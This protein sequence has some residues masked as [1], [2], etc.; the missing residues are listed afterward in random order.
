MKEV[1]L[2][3]LVVGLLLSLTVSAQS[4]DYYK[5]I[6]LQGDSDAQFNL[7]V[8]YAIGMGVEKNL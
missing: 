6:A 3:I 5:V 4:F 7:G 8:S 2:S 1:K